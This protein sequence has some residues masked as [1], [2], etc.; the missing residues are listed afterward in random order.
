MLCNLMRVRTKSLAPTSSKTES[1]TCTTTNA[2]PSGFRKALPL[3]PPLS[4]VF[5]STR[6]ARNA[7]AVPKTIAQISE[8]PIVKPR[9]R[10][11]GVTFTG[12]ACGPSEAISSSSRLP[13]HAKAIPASPPSVASSALSVNNCRARRKRPAPTAIRT[14][15]SLWRAA[16]WASS[17]LATLA[18]A[19]NNTSATTPINT[20][21]EVENCARSVERPRFKGV[22]STLAF[23]ISCNLSASGCA[24]ARAWSACLKIWLT[25]AFAWSSLTP[26]FKRANT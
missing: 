25:T 11:F 20:F 7:G 10:M 13:H 9:T 15:N 4:D 19:I 5:G 23:W 2:L 8:T 22:S 14:A 3:L 17:K 21:N 16:P 1:A 12:T 18:L 6:E 24:P 26:S